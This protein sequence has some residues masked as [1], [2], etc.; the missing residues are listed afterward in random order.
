MLGG[1]LRRREAKRPARMDNFLLIMS[2]CDAALTACYIC[3]CMFCMLVCLHACA[4]A[5]NSD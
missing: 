2:A 1:R 3:N 4:C 5:R